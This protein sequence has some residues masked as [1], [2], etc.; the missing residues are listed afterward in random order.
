MARRKLANITGVDPEYTRKFQ[1]TRPAAVPQ[2]EEV[3]VTSKLLASDEHTTQGVTEQGEAPTLTAAAESGHQDASDSTAETKKPRVAGRRGRQKRTETLDVVTEPV[4]LTKRSARTPEDKSLVDVRLCALE[5]HRASLD[6]LA[7]AGFPSK[8][9]MIFAGKR[10]LAG[11][12]LRPVY[13]QPANAPRITVAPYVYRSTKAIEDKLIA[14]IARKHDPL[15][16]RGKYA[17]VQG[18][19]EE[20]FWDELDRVIKELEDR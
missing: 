12:A 6:R 13:V 8:D 3:P 4:S 18:Q 20:A 16:V 19:F 17:M 11:I 10:L 7:A 15:G 5:R 2:V 14:T 1:A 9:V